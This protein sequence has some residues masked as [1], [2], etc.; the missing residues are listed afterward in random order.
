MY[1]YTIEE[2]KVINKLQQKVR[3]F[4]PEATLE[5]ADEGYTVINADHEDILAE[6]MLPMGKTPME[7]W[8]LAM[9]T[10]K[11]TK[12]FNRTHPERLSLELEEEKTNRLVRRNKRT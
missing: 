10:A 6:Y 1:K 4:Y 8:Q 2:T 11:T 5:K 7:A 3:K 9:L 12:N